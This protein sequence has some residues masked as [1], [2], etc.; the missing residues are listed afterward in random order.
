M[1]LKRFQDVE[2]IEQDVERL[3]R[4]IEQLR[5]I[6]EQYF[7]GL[8]KENPEMMREKVAK[9]IRK[10]HG[11]PIQNARLKFKYQQAIA[12]F[13]TYCTYWDRILRRIEE[14]T[15]ERDVF[16]S[17]LRGS[18]NTSA[19]SDQ[20]APSQDMYNLYQSFQTAKDSLAQPLDHVSFKKFQ[21]QLRT[22]KQKLESKHS[23]HEISFKVTREK[24]KVKITPVAVKKA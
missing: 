7:M 22:Q 20:P 2:Q 4:D 12:R 3:Q 23:G 15:Y 13:N 8:I 9:L 18:K 24:G 16:K 5:K 1:A 14:G 21:N 6:Y 19:K 17:K 10:N 11:I